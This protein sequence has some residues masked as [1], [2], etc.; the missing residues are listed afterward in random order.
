MALSS[1]TA[2]KDQDFGDSHIDVA[3]SEKRLIRV[4]TNTYKNTGSTYINIKLFKKK[5]EGSEF[6]LQQRVGLTVREFQDLVANKENINMGPTP[7]HN[8]NNEDKVS[9]RDAQTH[10]RSNEAKRAK[11]VLPED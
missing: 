11:I 6:R 9:K 2:T 5:D 4:T 7:L 3:E 1:L 8:S 10:K